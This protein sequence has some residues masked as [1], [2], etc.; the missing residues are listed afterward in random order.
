MILAKLASVDDKLEQ[1]N[2]QEK[3]SEIEV[4]LDHF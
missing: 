3:R 2:V 1:L 4:R